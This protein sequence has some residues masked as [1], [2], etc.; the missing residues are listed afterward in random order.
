MLTDKKI[1][2]KVDGEHRGVFDG[3]H[4]VVLMTHRRPED[5]P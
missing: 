3:Y 5:G 1:S 4:P 2:G